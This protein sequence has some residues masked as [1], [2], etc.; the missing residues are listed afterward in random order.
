MYKILFTSAL[1]FTHAS[2][3]ADGTASAAAKGGFDIMSLLPFVMIFIVFYFLLIRPQ[4]KKVK[5]HQSLLANLRRGDKVVT[6][7]GIIG[8]IDRIINDQEVSIEI[9]EGVKTKFAKQM[10]TDVIVKG[11]PVADKGAPIV[12]KGTEP[13]ESTGRKAATKKTL[14]KKKPTKK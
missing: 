12:D 14:T 11:T 2:L 3:Y 9:A 5:Q 13:K 4:Q 7:G 10:I 6:A 1:A 8:Q